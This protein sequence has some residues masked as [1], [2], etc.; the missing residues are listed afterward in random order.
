MT[1]EIVSVRCD[2][3]LLFALTFTCQQVDNIFYIK[4][5]YQTHHCLSG[6]KASLVLGM[7]LEE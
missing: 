4:P 3:L 5:N 7:S 2:I 6:C 1:S